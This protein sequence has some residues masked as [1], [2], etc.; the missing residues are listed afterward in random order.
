LF[1]A[2]CSGTSSEDLQGKFPSS[3]K[4][5]VSLATST[6]SPSGARSVSASDDILLVDATASAAM[7]LTA[8]KTFTFTLVT[9]D[10]IIDTSAAAGVKVTLKN[11]SKTIGEGY[12]TILDA[13]TVTAT[14]TVTSALSLNTTAKTLTVNT[15]TASILAERAGVDDEVT[16]SLTYGS[17]TATGNLL[18]Y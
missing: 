3:T 16:A 5:A 6:S 1:L 14:I 9:T 18:R 12:T 4:V 7:L 15:D 11:G 10:P 17:N 13:S 8:G 2:A